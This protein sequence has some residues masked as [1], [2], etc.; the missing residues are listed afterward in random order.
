MFSGC[1]TSF[2][3]RRPSRRWGASCARWAIASCRPARA[4]M[5]RRWE[6]S[7]F[8]KG[9]RRAPGRDRA[10]GGRQARRHRGLVRRRGPGRAK[11]Q[12]D[13]ALD[14]ARHPPLSPTGSTDG[15]HLHLQ[16][17]LSRN[18]RRGWPDP[19]LVQHR[20]DGPA[21]GRNVG[22]GDAGEALRA[23]GRPSRLAHFRA[24]GCAGEHHHR[25]NAGQVP[26]AEPGRKRVDTGP[27]SMTFL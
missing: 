8:S 19:A 25:A 23:A 12:D 16:R 9:F 14:P 7:S 20:G 5:R 13:A 11:E 17:D 18:R 26:R 4:T 15:V 22:P 27:L 10:R 24:P 3:S 6:P 2:R 1:R 21:S